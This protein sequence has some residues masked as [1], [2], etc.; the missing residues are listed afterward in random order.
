M[1]RIEFKP[2]IIILGQIE[3]IEFLCLLIKTTNKYLKVDI[4][5]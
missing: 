5:D 4:K 3:L 2:K 1:K